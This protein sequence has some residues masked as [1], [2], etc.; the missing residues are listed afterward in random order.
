MRFP[1]LRWR[2]LFAPALHLAGLHADRVIYVEAGSDT[3]VML[4]MEECLRHPGLGGV[5]GEIGKYSTTASVV[6][7]GCQATS[8]SVNRA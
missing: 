2:D 6:A 1:G 5:V 3:N 8:S 7:S 4:A